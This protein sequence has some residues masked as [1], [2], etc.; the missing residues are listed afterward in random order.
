[1]MSSLETPPGAGAPSLPPDT[2]ATDPVAGVALKTSTVAASVTPADEKR[3]WEMMYHIE[4]FSPDVRDFF[5]SMGAFLAEEKR[6]AEVA[7]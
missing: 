1:M 4:Q 6:K 5:I 2:P 7:P 3:L